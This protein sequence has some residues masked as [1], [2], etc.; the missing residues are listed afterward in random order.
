MVMWLVEVQKMDVN[1]K[2]DS[3]WTCLHWA[4]YRLHSA[5]FDWLIDVAKADVTASDCRDWTCLHYATYRYV[6]LWLLWLM[7]EVWSWVCCY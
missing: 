6:M 7:V 4:A 5:L 1:D 2:D 3:G